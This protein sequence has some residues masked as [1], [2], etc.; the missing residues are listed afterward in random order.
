MSDGR[1]FPDIYFCDIFTFPIIKNTLAY[2]GLGIYC[3]LR[4]GNIRASYMSI[5]VSSTNFFETVCKEDE[6]IMAF[7]ASFILLIK[8]FH[9]NTRVLMTLYNI[10]SPE[11]L[12]GKEIYVGFVS[13]KVSP[14]NYLKDGL[15]FFDD[16]SIDSCTTTKL[17]D[18]M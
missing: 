13:T 6:C 17:L 12:M 4:K 9:I 10:K 8:V 15:S 1:F 3:E 18:Y 7:D 14:I 5:G 2:K 16:I 11:K